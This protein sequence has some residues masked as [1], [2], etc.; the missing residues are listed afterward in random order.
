MEA[1][2]LN[3]IIERLENM[4]PFTDN[5]IPEPPILEKELYEKYV[6]PNFIRC[7]AIPKNKLEIGK[8]YIGNCRNA[9]EA[10]WL[11][12]YFEYQRYKFGY[13]YPEK[14]KHFEDD[15]YTGTDVFVPIRLK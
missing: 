9:N 14:I 8:T 5:F 11:G 4:K 3:K 7:G 2:K 13:T 10:V 15:D 1:Q 6:I 12:D